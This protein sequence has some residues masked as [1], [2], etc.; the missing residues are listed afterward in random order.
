ME[1]SQ[2]LPKLVGTFCALQLSGNAI[3][4]PEIIIII[5]VGRGQSLPAAIQFPC[6]DDGSVSMDFDSPEIGCVI[7]SA[8]DDY[9]TQELVAACS[10]RLQQSITGRNERGNGSRNVRKYF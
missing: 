3:V 5:L 9:R 1:K 10:G 7:T 8:M 4:I 6:E 2:L